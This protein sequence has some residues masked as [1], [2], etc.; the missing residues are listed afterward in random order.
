MRGG[1]L[2]SPRGAARTVVTGLI[3]PFSLHL[4]VFLLPVTL[5][6]MRTAP[7]TPALVVAAAGVPRSSAKYPRTFAQAASSPQ[8]GIGV[9]GHDDVIAVDARGT[10]CP[11]PSSS[12][13]QMIRRGYYEAIRWAG[14]Q[15]R[16]SVCVVNEKEQVVYEGMS[17]CRFRRHRVRC[18][19]G[20]GDGSWRDESTHASSSSRL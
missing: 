2:P 13:N 14:R 18:F 12:R 10:K 16:P 5:E 3:W 15:K 20:T 1:R 7:L 4:D 9:L 19:S 17:C 6:R 8:V 11:L